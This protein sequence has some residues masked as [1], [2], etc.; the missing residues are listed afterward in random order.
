IS[1]PKS[2]DDDAEVKL[3]KSIRSLFIPDD[4]HFWL[5]LDYSQ[6]EIRLLAHYA[7]GP[8]SD[9][10]RHKYLTSDDVD[11][12]AWCAEMSGVDRHEAKKINFSIIYGMGAK[13]VAAKLGLSYVEGKEFLDD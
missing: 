1:N 11:Y 9:D 5:K 3:G 6:I 7:T 2:D 12:H 4:D 10:I 8:K 13:R